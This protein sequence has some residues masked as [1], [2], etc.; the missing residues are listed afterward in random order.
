MGVPMTASN[1]SQKKTT[2]HQDEVVVINGQKM[3]LGSDGSLRPV[4]KKKLFNLGRDRVKDNA[5]VKNQELI[6]MLAQ[7]KQND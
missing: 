4:I 7:A 1:D 5:A 3:L 2:V 6:E